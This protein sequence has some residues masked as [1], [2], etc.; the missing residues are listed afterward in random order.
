[1]SQGNAEI[2][3][4]AMEAFN[5]RDR[6]GW[7]RLHDPGVEFQA[8]PGWPESETV[9]GR[10]AVWEFIAAL[11]EAWEPS[12]FEMEEVID[13]GSDRLLA[14]FTRPVQGKTSGIADVLDYWC[15]FTFRAG[16]IVGTRW[17]A[18]RPQA[19]EAVGLSE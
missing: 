11:V 15:V 19:L 9:R 4:Q 2:V 13:A 16:K 6:D 1:M 8:D 12:D 17:F 5:R 18:T 7:L 14:R 3:R 10:E